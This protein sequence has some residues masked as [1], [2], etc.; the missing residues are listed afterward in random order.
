MNTSRIAVIASVLAAVFWAAK[1]VAIGAAGGLDR[2]PLESPLFFLGL[3]SAI[4]ANVALALSVA[5]G[6]AWWVRGAAALGV[7]VALFAVTALLDAAVH[8]LVDGDHW[9]LAEVNLW[10]DALVVLGLSVALDRR[11]PAPA[12]HEHTSSKAF[13]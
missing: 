10:I 6:R 3:A 4:V 11:R 7:V 13:A 9:V 12:E 8:G 2:S 1:S 5:A